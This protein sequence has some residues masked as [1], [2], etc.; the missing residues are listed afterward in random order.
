M[1]YQEFKNNNN[2]KY[3]D[4]DKHYGYQCWDL[5]QYYFTQVLNVPDSVLSGCGYVKNMILW[6]WKYDMLLEYF[7]EIDVHTMFP[8]DVVIWTGGYGGH[9]AVFDNFDGNQNW[10]FS[11]DPDLNTPCMIRNCNM[12]GIHAFRRKKEV[13]P[14]PEP[15]PVITPNVER[16]EYKNQIEVKVEK[17]R[18]RSEPNLNGN[19]I[20]FANV[21]FYNYFETKEE[22]NYIWYR[23]AENNWI[24]SNEEWTTVY[25]EKPKKEYV[26]LEILEKKDGYVLLDLGKVWIKKD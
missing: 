5:G 7:D 10:Y 4:Y 24:A 19:I 21:G 23:I 1:T 12:D 26:E 6:E 17:L 20:G 18:V 14:T 3:L 2:N 9:I 8:G 11:Q 13:P 22:D 15:S 16:D 25:P